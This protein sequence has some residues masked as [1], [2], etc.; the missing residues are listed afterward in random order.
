MSIFLALGFSYISN[1]VHARPHAGN[2]NRWAQ[3]C[4]I[5]SKGDKVMKKSVPSLFLTFVFIT[6][7][8]SACA[9]APTL[10]PT[11]VPPTFTPLPTETLVP[12]NTPVPTNTSVPTKTPISPTATVPAPEK[13]LEYLNN[14]QVVYNDTFDNTTVSGWGN[15][16]WLDGG[17]IQNDV[18]EVIGKNWNAV[19]RDVQRT[20]KEGEGIILDFTYN[21]GSVFEFFFAH[22]DWGTD[23]LRRFGIYISGGSAQADLWQGKN[24]L[25]FNNLHG[26]LTLKADIKYS[27][28]I[29]VLPDS[30]FLGVIWSPSDPSK[31]LVYHEKLGKSWVNLT[32]TFTIGADKGT[33][34]FDNFKEIKFDSVVK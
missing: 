19:G 20:Y 17:K 30:E 3:S 8:A 10:P 22:G 23:P 28:L 31:T 29:A 2:A 18:L 26:N 14:V 25:G 27:L 16:W 11:S 4:A 15:G 33:I 1:I 34:L 24:G 32:Y 6:V 9:P 7:L 21:K 13:S 12:T 5:K